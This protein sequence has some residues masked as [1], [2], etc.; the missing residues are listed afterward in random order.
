MPPVRSGFL[1]TVWR[2]VLARRDQARSP[3]ARPAGSG[4]SDP[5]G[6]PLARGV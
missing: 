1:I 2:R 3:H 6:W 4:L 5:S